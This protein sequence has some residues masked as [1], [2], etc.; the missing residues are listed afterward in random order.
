MT[1]LRN[2]TPEEFEN[3][4]KEF[5]AIENPNYEAPKW[6][7]RKASLRTLSQWVQF[8]LYKIGYFEAP[9]Y[10]GYC[11]HICGTHPDDD[12]PSSTM[13]YMSKPA[14]N[15]WYSYEF[16]VNGCDWEEEHQCENCGTV[17]SFS[18]GSC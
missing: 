17:Y 4:Q 1:S 8:A 7:P 13:L 9:K 5:E 14:N 16:G 10:T 2:F 12:Y 3:S 18:N 11:C 15:P 6:E